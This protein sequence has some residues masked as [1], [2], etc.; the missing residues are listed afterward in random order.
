M[1]PYQAGSGLHGEGQPPAGGLKSALPLTGYVT[2]VNLSEPQLAH[3]FDEDNNTSHS[4]QRLGE[5]V[6]SVKCLA[7]CQAPGKWSSSLLLP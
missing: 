6:A 5:L 1:P 4:P 2:F 7:N 3:L